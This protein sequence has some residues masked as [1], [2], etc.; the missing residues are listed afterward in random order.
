M[1]RTPLVLLL[2]ALLTGCAGA[3]PEPADG[4][5]PARVPPMPLP[6]PPPSPLQAAAAAPAAMPVQA[7]PARALPADTVR[8]LPTGFALRLDSPDASPADFRVEQSDSGL[9]VTTGPA[10]ILYP[11]DAAHRLSGDYSVSATVRQ[12]EPSQHPEAYG[13]FI[14]GRDLQGE[15]QRYTYF[16]VRQ[17]GKVLIKQRLATE[18][19]TLLPWTETTAV[20]VPGSGRGGNTL[21]VRVAGDAA[22]FLVND[23]E[24]ARIPR[25]QLET[26]GVVGYRVNHNLRVQLGPLRVTQP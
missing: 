4:P 18:T 14:G 21:A 16:L 15:T 7:A 9:T 1:D 26:E 3:T 11:T 6:A 13:I 10:G 2:A 25:A 17:D 22:V 24:V 23:T 8:M 19:P 12:L 5:A 20:R